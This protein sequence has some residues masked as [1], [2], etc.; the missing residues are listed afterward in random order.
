MPGAAWAHDFFS[1]SHPLPLSP[2]AAQSAA[3]INS[4]VKGVQIG[5]ITY[6]FRA[7]PNA[8]DIIQAFVTIG[9]GEM[10]I[11]SGDVEKLVGA[12]TGRAERTPWRRAATAETFRPIREKIAAA[13]IDL[14]LLCYN[15]NVASTTD[16]DIEY[17]FTMARGLG[18]RAMSTS[19]QVSMAKR[20]APF[21]ERHR[22]RVGFHGHDSVERADEVHNEASFNAVMDAGEYLGPN[23]DI[24]H[25][26]VAGGD[27]VAFIRKYHGRITNIHLKD[28]K[29][30]GTNV[31]WGLGDT[32]TRAVL[33]LLAQEKYDLPANIEYVHEDPE[34]PVAGVRKCFE[35]VKAAL[36]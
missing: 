15:M 3:P 4:R 16:D 20:L 23:L 29:K 18:V 11:M 12:P 22:M 26:M 6:S 36:A 10:E 32:P 17:A 21:A 14:A 8:N 27:P 2:S 30:D 7:L 35:F 24:G 34:G 31:A 5:A 33:Q 28:K 13:G 25:F 1:P 9:L 19:T